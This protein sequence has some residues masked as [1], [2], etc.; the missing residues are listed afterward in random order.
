M[1]PAPNPVGAEKKAE[2][3]TVENCL[4]TINQFLNE[5]VGARKQ[6][7]EWV[8]NRLEELFKQLQKLCLVAR[9]EEIFKYF[10]E[11]E[12]V[13]RY[14]FSFSQI[15]ADPKMYIKELIG[16][17]DCWSLEND[18]VIDV[19]DGMIIRNMPAPQ[20]LTYI[21]SFAFFV[22]AVV[23]PPVTVRSAPLSA[24]AS[25]TAPLASSS[26]ASSEASS[27]SRAAP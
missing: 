10:D 14:P 27:S 20:S 25:S 16:V 6:R 17:A 24:T 15:T 12:H 1:T 8:E 7:G 26:A 3:L 11:K 4:N 13:K 23:P 9:R 19:R 22:P 18:Y 2:V 21:G 5:Q